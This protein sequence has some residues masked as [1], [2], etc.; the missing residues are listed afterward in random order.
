[1]AAPY[2]YFSF[3]TKIV[4]SIRSDLLNFCEAGTAPSLHSFSSTAY[5]V[6]AIAYF[7]AQ[8]GFVSPLQLKQEQPPIRLLGAAPV[9]L[10][11]F[12]CYFS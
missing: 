7:F 12:N 9:F 8:N 10:S 3:Y 2:L 6:L 1:M 4:L 5:L 11:L